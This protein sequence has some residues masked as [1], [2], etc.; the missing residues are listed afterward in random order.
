MVCFKDRLTPCTEEDCKCSCSD[1]RGP[2]TIHTLHTYIYIFF[3]AYTYEMFI[4][5]ILYI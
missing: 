2:K 1:E 5:G 4:S 3:T